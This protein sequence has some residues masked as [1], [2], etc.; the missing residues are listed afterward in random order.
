VH[1]CPLW[2]LCLTPPP[3]HIH[4]HTTTP[5][6][7]L[8]AILTHLHTTHHIHPRPPLSTVAAHTPHIHVSTTTHTHT[9]THTHTRIRTHTTPTRIR[10][11][12][13]Y[14]TRRT[15]RPLDHARHTTLTLYRIYTSLFQLQ[16]HYHQKWVFSHMTRPDIGP[17]SLY[18]SGFFFLF[19]S[20]L[21][22]NS[23]EGSASSGFATPV[24]TPRAN[25]LLFIMDLTD[26][27]SASWSGY[28]IE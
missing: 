20:K 4:H 7:T 23:W 22:R 9:H 3:H 2:S 24:R 15:P 10:T 27:T 28:G 14:T 8:H 6:P 18:F 17:P 13:R 26:R 25:A 1:I 12:R 21:S 11:H 5:H 16:H 19:F